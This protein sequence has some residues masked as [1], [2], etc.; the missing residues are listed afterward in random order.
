MLKNKKVLST[1]LASVI[2][3][4][5]ASAYASNDSD[6]QAAFEQATVSAMQAVQTA[7]A[8]V[9]GKATDVDFKFKNGSSIYK[10]D[11]IQDNQGNGEKHEIVVDAKTGEILADN[12]KDKHHKKNKVQPELKLSL[13]QAIDIA[14]QKAG[15]KVKEA[16]LDREHDT[17]HYKIESIKEGK[18]YKTVIDANS[19]NVIQ[20]G[21]DN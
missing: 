14:L 20:S 17:M 19:G 21:I 13:E 16:E 3:I 5:G 18:T 6:K 15:G 4:G 7:T 11:V 12:V 9:A 2:L 1:L 10:V 8:K